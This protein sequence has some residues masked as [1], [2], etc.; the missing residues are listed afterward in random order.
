MREVDRAS[1]PTSCGC[2]GR[3]S[4]DRTAP[5]DVR[6]VIVVL[7]AW[8]VSPIDLIPEFIPGLG[9]FDDVVVAIVALRYVPAT[10]R[11][12]RRWRARWPGSRRR[13]ATS[14]PGSSAS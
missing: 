4:A 11:H 12:R 6:V 8:I 7:V 3:S 14:W 1:C 10:D 5:L 9:P 2:C 13:V